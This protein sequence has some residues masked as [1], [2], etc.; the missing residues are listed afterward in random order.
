MDMQFPVLPEDEFVLYA[1]VRIHRR[2]LHI[3]V[4]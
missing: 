2:I 3:L 4:H 1:T